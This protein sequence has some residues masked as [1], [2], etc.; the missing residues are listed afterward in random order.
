MIQYDVLE[1]KNNFSKICGM[2]KNKEEDMV[3][4]TVDGNPVAQI[5][6]YKENKKTFGC[7]KDKYHFK[8]DTNWFDNEISEMFIKE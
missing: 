6:P 5:I 4:I 8:E 1:A 7:L 2:L 3:I